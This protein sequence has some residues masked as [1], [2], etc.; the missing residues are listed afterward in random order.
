MIVSPNAGH[1]GPMTKAACDQT[2]FISTT[3]IYVN[4]E[5]KR[6]EARKASRKKYQK[7]K[8]SRKRRQL[9]EARKVS[10]QHA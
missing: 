1:S 3:W 8:K 7:E 4:D 2:F 6:E 10:A 9:A 5:A